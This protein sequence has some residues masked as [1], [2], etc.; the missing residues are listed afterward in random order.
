MRQRLDHA[1]ER[2]VVVSHIHPRRRRAAAGARRMVVRQPQ[3]AQGRHRV[4]RDLRAEVRD[5]ALRALRV[6]QLEVPARVRRVGMRREPRLVRHPSAVGRL[7]CELAIVPKRDA[8]TTCEVPQIARRWLVHVVGRQ[9]VA[10]EA[11]VVVGA[12]AIRVVARNRLLDVVRRVRGRAPVV[13]IAAHLGIHEEAVEHAE[14][15]G[16]HVRVRRDVTGK[17]GERGVG[18]GAVEI[19]EHLVERPVLADHV[20]DVPERRQSAFG[21]RVVPAVRDRDSPRQLRPFMIG[22][23]RE[24][25]ER[26]AGLAQG[27]LERVLRALAAARMAMLRIRSGP[28]SLRVENPQ[29]IA[30][31]EHGGGIPLDRDATHE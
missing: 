29:R 10:I 23:N 12:A 30:A 7:A 25:A 24:T 8:R 1:A 20:D 9:R 27:V 18:V 6:R 15:L 17:V 5:P 19:A 16:E 28:T 11:V 14:A 4:A 3:D 13:A 2:Q 22:R 31:R 21:R 26:A